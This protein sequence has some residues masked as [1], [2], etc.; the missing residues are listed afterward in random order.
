MRQDDEEGQRVKGVKGTWGQD[1]THGVSGYINY[2]CRCDVCRDAW[3]VYHWDYMQ[4]HPE[5]IAKNAER[6]RRRRAAKKAAR[7]QF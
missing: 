3:R 5:Q 1:F 4:R 6:E 2:A 7:G